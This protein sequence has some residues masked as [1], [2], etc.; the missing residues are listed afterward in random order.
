MHKRAFSDAFEIDV[1]IYEYV[2]IGGLMA[3]FTPYNRS[4]KT[5]QGGNGSRG[6]HGFRFVY[7]WPTSFFAVD[8]YVAFPGIIIPTGPES[9]RFMADFWVNREC[10]QRHSSTS[11]SR[12]TT[13]TLAED[14]E[15]V[16]LCSSP[17]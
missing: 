6:G 14:S 2:N 17:A 11:G 8:D 15:A 1:D 9:C 12:C 7:I 3:Q 4:A 16:R 13:Q 5:Y 10:D